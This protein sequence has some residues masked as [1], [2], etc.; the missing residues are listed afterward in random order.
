MF[1]GHG[2]L[3]A[4]LVACVCHPGAAAFHGDCMVLHAPRGAAGS[5]VA[6]AGMASTNHL[7]EEGSW[8]KDSHCSSLVSLQGWERKKT[9]GVEVNASPHA[10]QVLNCFF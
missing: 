10:R 5:S 2:L 6:L 4:A 7:S 9:H 1:Q 3:L 8:R